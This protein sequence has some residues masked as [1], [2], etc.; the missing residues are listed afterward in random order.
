MHFLFLG[1]CPIIFIFFSCCHGYKHGKNFL[2]TESTLLAWTEYVHAWKS[3]NHVLLFIILTKSWSLPLRRVAEHRLQCLPQYCCCV[4]ARL[5]V[6]ASHLSSQTRSHEVS[7]RSLTIINQK[8]V[9]NLR[10]K[11]LRPAVKSAD[12]RWSSHLFT[13]SFCLISERSSGKTAFRLQVSFFSFSSH[14]ALL[15]LLLPRN[16]VKNGG[17]VLSCLK[18]RMTSTTSNPRLCLSSVCAQRQRKL[19]CA[20][21]SHKRRLLYVYVPLYFS[22]A[23]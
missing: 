6:P 20:V 15:L 2:W 23:A 7:H 9:P 13:L 5:P 18:D 11:V 16:R 22:T 4:F 14:P 12:N 21:C 10:F 1:I 3:K 17:A 8:N 19:P